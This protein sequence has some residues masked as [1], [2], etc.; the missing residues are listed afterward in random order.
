[1]TI[2]NKEILT[3]T[4][5]DMTA[6]TDVLCILDDVLTFA[7]QDGELIEYATGLKHDINEFLSTYT[8]AEVD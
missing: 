2:R 5:D 6:F 3:L 8:E 4:F 7:N 1:M